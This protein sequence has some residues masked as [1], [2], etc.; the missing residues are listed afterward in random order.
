MEIENK[1]FSGR[2]EKKL[3]GLVFETSP[4]EERSDDESTAK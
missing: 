1:N 4:I 3:A 2:Q